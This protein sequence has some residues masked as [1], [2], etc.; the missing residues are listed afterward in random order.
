MRQ[1]L[2][3]LRTREPKDVGK[4]SRRAAPSVQGGGVCLGPNVPP[5]PPAVGAGRESARGTK[6]EGPI[7]WDW[8]LQQRAR[9]LEGMFLGSALTVLCLMIW[10][11]DERAKLCA[12]PVAAEALE[13]DRVIMTPSAGRGKGGS[14]VKV[15]NRRRARG[16]GGGDD[17]STTAR[18]DGAVPGAGAAAVAEGMVD[19]TYHSFGPL[20]R[21]RGRNGRCSW[22][23][24]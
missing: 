4:R 21:P 2:L 12:A 20:G 8:G 16:K 3:K 19:P 6:E 18:C 11:C 1:P 24:K 15:P 10:V 22:P 14:T 13:A 5:S 7:E 23:C 17:G 9:I